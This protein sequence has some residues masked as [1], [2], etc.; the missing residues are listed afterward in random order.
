MIKLL[1]NSIK[2]IFDAGGWRTSAH[3]MRHYRIA[4]RDVFPDASDHGRE[5]A[6]PIF[7]LAMSSYSEGGGS[8]RMRRNTTV[9]N[10][11]LN[12]N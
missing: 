12:L 8:R 9:H 3:V 1:D 11:L 2:S 6:D 10:H 5:L 4:C 7:L